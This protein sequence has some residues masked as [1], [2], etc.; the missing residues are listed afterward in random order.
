MVKKILLIG[1]SY[2]NYN[3][4]IASAFDKDKFEVKII[5]YS[6]LFGQKKLNNK[7]SYFLSRNKAKTTQILLTELNQFITTTYLQYHPDIVMIIKGDVIFEETVLEMTESK[8]ILWMLDGIFYYPQSVKLADIMDAVFLFEK[9]DVEKVK[10]INVNTYYLPPSYDDQIFRKLQLKKDIDLLFIGTL[11]D[12]R[13]ELFEKLHKKFPNLNMKI[14][15]K[16]YSLYKTP[17]KYLKSLSNKI[18]INQFV[19]PTE[20]NILYNRSKVCLN[21]HHEQSI[22]G[23]NPRFFEI[24]G[25]NA[26]QFV[27]HKPFIDEYFSD[28]NVRTYKSEE[29]LFEM[30]SQ[31]F[32]SN[33]QDDDQNLYETVCNHH[34]FRN[35]I[36]SILDKI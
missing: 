34:T 1:P 11:Y 33:I 2:F 22:Y 4:S 28:Y 35:R 14:F 10:K 20:A 18:F 23:V 8:N 7:I 24:Y 12:S 36:D 9:S 32:N 6:D 15:C 29:E 31:K 26:L 3:Q 17:I 13:I 16:R 27:D 21:M 19:T 5:D 25:A 30:I